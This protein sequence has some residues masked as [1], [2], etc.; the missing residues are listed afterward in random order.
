MNEKTADAG[1]VLLDPAEGGSEKTRPTSPL[2]GVAF[3]GLI[4]MAELLVAGGAI[5][6]APSADGRTPLMMAAAFNRVEMVR[7]C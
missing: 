7:G 2:S 3:K 1:R 5:V 4:D 6:D